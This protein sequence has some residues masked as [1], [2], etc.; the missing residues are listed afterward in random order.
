MRLEYAVQ[1]S[2]NG[3]AQAFV[4]GADF[5]RGHPS[6]LILG[7][8]IIYGHGLSEVLRG[9]DERKSGATIFGYWVDDPERYGVI[10]FDDKMRVLLDRGK[11]EA[12]EI[13]LGG[14]RG[15]FLRRGR[16]RAGQGAQAVGARRIRDHRS[17]QPLR[18]SRGA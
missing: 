1:P 15:L 8:N 6:C 16:G 9:A 12:A 14:D 10:E 3:L 11:A 4:I 18:R 2:P 13:E 5:V 7:D 17:Q